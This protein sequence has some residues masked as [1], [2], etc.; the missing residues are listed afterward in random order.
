MS[1]ACYRITFH[2][3]VA[4]GWDPDDVKLNMAKLFKLD[5]NNPQ[6]IQK[7][8]LLFSGHTV[9]I[10]EGIDANTA[11]TYVDAIAKIGG[12]AYM[13]VKCELPDGIEERRFILRRQR[14]NRRV[15]ARMASI[16]PDRR[17]NNGRRACDQNI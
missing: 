8:E 3:E 7:L 4:N 12:E 6:H 17:E 2:G 11:Q 5:Q 14:G 10:K 15:A 1:A 9:T 16:R 13:K